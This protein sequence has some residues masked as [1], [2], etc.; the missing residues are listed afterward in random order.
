MPIDLRSPLHS[1]ASMIADFLADNEPLVSGPCR[2]AAN[3][4]FY[5]TR[6]LF[7]MKTPT[8]QFPPHF[9]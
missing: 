2:P 8:S 4:E 3:P 9:L 1:S 6:S 7:V 5:G